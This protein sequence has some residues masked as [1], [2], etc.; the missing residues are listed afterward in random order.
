MT[1]DHETSEDRLPAIIEYLRMHPAHTLPGAQSTGDGGPTVIHVHE[2]HH[3]APP[4]P[5]PPPPKP[6]VAEQ[7]IPWLYFALMACIIGT[8]CAAILAAVIVALVVG[9]LAVA[10]VAAVLA[11]LV[12]TV[13][14]SQIN[15]G[16][17]DMA[18]QQER[19]RR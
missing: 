16:L 3:Y 4:P 11:H 18:R 13:R 17:M 7:V 12:K 10:V 8:I 19:K 6:T 14:E 9:L 2:H 15:V 1:M 5:P